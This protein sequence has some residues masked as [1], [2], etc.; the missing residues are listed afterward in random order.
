MPT[1][2][3]EC[4]RPIHAESYTTCTYGY[5]VSLRYKTYGSTV[6]RAVH[7]EIRNCMQS[8]TPAISVHMLLRV[9]PVREYCTCE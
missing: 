4:Y 6:R 3:C 1:L 7:V 5:V 9:P 2:Y 8:A